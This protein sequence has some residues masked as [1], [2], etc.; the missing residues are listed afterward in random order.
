MDYIVQGL[1]GSTDLLT[2]Y[3]AELFWKHKKRCAFS[4]ISLNRGSVCC[5]KSSLWKRVTHLSHTV[6]YHGYWSPSN[7][8][9]YGIKVIDDQVLLEYS[10]LDTKIVKYKR[11]EL[12]QRKNEYLCMLYTDLYRLTSVLATVA[13]SVKTAFTYIAQYTT[14]ISMG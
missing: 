8:S 4:F 1:P 3:Y 10:G 2:L 14:T 9:S 6:K 11:D 7:V 12:V 13:L 5:W